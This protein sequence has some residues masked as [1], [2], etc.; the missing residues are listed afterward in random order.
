MA[1]GLA[2]FSGSLCAIALTGF[3]GFGK[4]TTVGG[5]LLLLGWLMI[6]LH[7]PRASL[8]RTIHNLDASAGAFRS[9]LEGPTGTD[10]LRDSTQTRLGA[11][12]LV[13]A[14]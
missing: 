6:I 14:I 1:G 8:T 12:H 11:L 7:K 5:L 10:L 4:I 9:G 3:K 2:L 13:S